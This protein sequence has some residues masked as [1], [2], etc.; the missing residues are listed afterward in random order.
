MYSSM[1]LAGFRIVV[2]AT[3]YFRT[4]RIELDLG[5]YAL[6]KELC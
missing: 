6:W 1:F 2:M 4:F 3:V 5:R